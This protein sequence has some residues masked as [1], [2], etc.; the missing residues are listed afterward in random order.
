[1]RGAMYLTFVIFKVLFLVMI[2]EDEVLITRI[3]RVYRIIDTFVDWI[4]L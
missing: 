3:N 4:E 2:D 1:M